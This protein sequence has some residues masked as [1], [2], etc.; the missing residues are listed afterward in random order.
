MK[1]QKQKLILTEVIKV[2]LGNKDKDV[3]VT[4]KNDKKIVK[5][6]KLN[7][8]LE[9][10]KKIL[11]VILLENEEITRLKKIEFKLF[12]VK[13][14]DSKLTNMFR[15]E[16]NFNVYKCLNTKK[17][18]HLYDNK[19]GWIDDE[20]YTILLYNSLSVSNKLL[21]IFKTSVHPKII[22]R[23]LRHKLD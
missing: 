3:Y 21:L 15:V 5:S 12:P 8:A 10:I 14:E 23:K 17:L 4:F 16:T 6:L 13:R 7:N 2:K 9:K 1:N 19:L 11:D 18:N 22:V 20:T